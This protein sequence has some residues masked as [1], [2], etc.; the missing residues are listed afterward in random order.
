MNAADLPCR[1]R[2]YADFVEQSYDLEGTDCREA[3][4]EIE[5]LRNQLAAAQDSRLPVEVYEGTD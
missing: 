5:R 4:D 2:A 1:L 3:A